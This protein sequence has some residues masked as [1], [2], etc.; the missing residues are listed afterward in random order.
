MK[1]TYEISEIVPFINWLYYYHVWGLSGKSQEDKMAMQRE[2]ISMLESWKS[3]YHTYALFSLLDACGDGDDIIVYL[4]KDKMSF[5]SMQNEVRIPMLRQQK[6]SAAGQFNLCLSDFIRPV[7]SGLKDKLGVFCCT[8]DG[9]IIEQYKGD[10]YLTMLAQTVCDRLAEATAEK[11]HQQVRK[12]YWG[13]APH[14]QLTMRQ[15]FREEYQ[16]IRPAV[17]YPSM[18]DTGIN[19]LIDDLLNLRQVNV[20][21]TDTGMMTPHASVSGLMFAHPKAHYFEVGKIGED[22]LADYAR[23]RGV[24]IEIMRCFLQSS[25]IKR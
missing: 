17:G 3:K 10:D 18:P 23:R 19:F 9:E 20:R 7:S 21:L 5:N 1:L 14:E 22:Q 11:M 2:A 6:A 25:L 4:H 16:G 24:P 12:K 13:Y 8:V 15:I